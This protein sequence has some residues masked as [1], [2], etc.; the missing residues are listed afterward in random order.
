[1]IMRNERTNVYGNKALPYVNRNV[2][3]ND[4]LYD[5]ALANRSNF[6][7]RMLGIGGSGIRRFD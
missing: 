5:R 3:S 6:Q 4:D 2:E 1:M 7:P